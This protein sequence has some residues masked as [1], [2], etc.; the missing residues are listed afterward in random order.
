MTE[1]VMQALVREVRGVQRLR[2]RYAQVEKDL[3]ER[4]MPGGYRMSLN[5]KPALFLMDQAL[6]RAERAAGS[7]D[8]QTCMAVLI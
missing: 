6:D 2:G 5:M 7:G 1:N 8:L 4:P 3:D